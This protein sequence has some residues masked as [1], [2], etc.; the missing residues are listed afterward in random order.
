MG[1]V[2]KVSS[3]SEIERTSIDYVSFY[4]WDGDWIHWDISQGNEETDRLIEEFTFNYAFVNTIG[5]EFII[6]DT[7]R[8]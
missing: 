6:V 1:N 7:N 5:R 2:R 3:F 8:K 4:C